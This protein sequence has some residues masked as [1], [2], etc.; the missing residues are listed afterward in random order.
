MPSA[1]YGLPSLPVAAQSRDLLA[2]EVL[3]RQGDPVSAIFGIEEGR[4]R[5]LRHTVDDHVAVL[6][7]VGKGEL[8]AEAALFSDTYHCDAVALVP[9]RIRVYPKPETLRALLSDS[10]MAVSFMSSLAHQVQDLRT[11]L[12]QR[13]IRSA[14]DR[15]TQFL[16]LSANAQDGSVHLKGTLMDL[17]AEIGL[18]HEALY[19][20]L[21]ALENERAIVRSKDRIVLLPRGAL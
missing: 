13:N 2:S 17:A 9:S 10:G 7:M 19:R 8:F 21:S 16:R 20:T 11:R 12:E 1:E 5:M 18:S 15:V 14:R 4:V 3:F 6:H